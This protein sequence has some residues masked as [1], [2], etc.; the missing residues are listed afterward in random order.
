MSFTA[1]PL[2]S[3]PQ[4]TPAQAATPSAISAWA[5][6]L[7]SAL[8]IWVGKENNAITSAVDSLNKEINSTTGLVITNGTLDVSNGDTLTTAGL[9]LTGAGTAYTLTGLSNNMT[10]NPSVY[11]TS[12]I[13]NPIASYSGVSWGYTTT[14]SDVT[15][16]GL[17]IQMQ[18]RTGLGSS[19]SNSG[20]KVGIDR[21]AHV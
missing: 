2:P 13:A 18:S 21:R 3:L 12:L 17:C 9:V 8:Q 6:Q 16:I 7:I 20:D 15:E 14:K 1:N 11:Q 19:V 5:N 10:G 4:L